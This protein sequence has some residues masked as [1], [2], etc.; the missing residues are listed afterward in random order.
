MRA[1]GHS[2]LI[3]NEIEKVRYLDVYIYIY[4]PWKYANL[5]L[6]QAKRAVCK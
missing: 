4:I 1:E 5:M 2:F 3:V 6:F